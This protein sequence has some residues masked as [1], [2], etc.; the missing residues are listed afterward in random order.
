[1]G[2][3]QK[4]Q[5]NILAANVGPTQDVLWDA[6]SFGFTITGTADGT[7]GEENWTF[8]FA[9]ETSSL[10]AAGPVRPETFRLEPLYPNPFNPITTLH[11]ALP[12]RSHVSLKIYDTSGRLVATLLD[13]SL[14]AGAHNLSWDASGLASG[15]YFFRLNASGKV[16][17]Q[18]GVLAK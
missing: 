7:E 16:L 18:R 9:E 4:I 12:Q 13:G 6:S 5:A 11:F 8:E 17:A 10:T 15:V 3:P 14:P 2:L 1:M